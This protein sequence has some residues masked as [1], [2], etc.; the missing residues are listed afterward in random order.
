MVPLDDPE[1]LAVFADTLVAAGD[2]HGTLIQLQLA[3][4][5]RPRDRALAR[6]EAQFRGLHARELLGPLR[7]ATSMVTMHWFRGF[8]WSA[9]VRSL[10]EVKPLRDD[11]KPRLPRV[12]EQLLELGVASQ[13]RNL[14]IE[15][16]SSPFAPEHV[17][18]AAEAV[19][20]ARPR[21]L[22][23]LELNLLV[24]NGDW[25][26]EGCHGPREEPLPVRLGSLEVRAD[27]ALLP[28]LRALMH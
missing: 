2:V 18:L 7:T 13:L 8:V 21:E 19:V 1:A 14:T 11:R 17:L 12:V 22:V 16:V 3:C 9:Q 26:D 28:G 25:Y 5:E 15:L 24:Q 23:S 20:R 4:G 27:S 6:A 10:C